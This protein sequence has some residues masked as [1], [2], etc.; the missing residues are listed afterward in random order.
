M[1][2]G[3]FSELA[4]QSGTP[5]VQLGCKDGYLSCP[6]ISQKQQNIC[7]GVTTTALQKDALDTSRCS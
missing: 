2:S 3:L 7:K 6:V 5:K 1:E 4:S